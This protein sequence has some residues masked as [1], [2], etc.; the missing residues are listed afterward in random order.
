MS[1]QWNEDNRDEVINKSSF[2]FNGKKK[3]V[4]SITR[5]INA[6]D[7]YVSKAENDLFL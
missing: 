7:H 4:N 1:C 2:W 6:D 5:V 3:L